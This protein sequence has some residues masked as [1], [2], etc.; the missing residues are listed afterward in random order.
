MEN[1]EKR[2]GTWK[3]KN[4]SD[5]DGKVNVTSGNKSDSDDAQI[6]FA[7][8]V[9]CHDEWILAYACSFHIC[10]NKDWFSTY[11][12]VQSGDVVRM[13]DDNPCEIV[14]IGS[15]QIRTHDGIIHT[16]TDVRDILG[17]ARNFISL[18]TLDVKGYKHSG[19]GG[20]LKITKGSLVSYDR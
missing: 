2:N 13:G 11:E 8:C 16:L 18:S 10:C 12:F 14:G 20:V 5:G 6:V 9:S 15:V 19:S 4:K 17:M 1:K 7:R 3:P